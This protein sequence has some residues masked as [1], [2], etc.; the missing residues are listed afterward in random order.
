MKKY[1]D[2]PNNLLKYDTFIQNLEFVKRDIEEKPIKAKGY[3]AI[4]LS[5]FSL[6]E[7]C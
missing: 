4:K 7:N 6:E 1:I 3:K 5:F 2:N